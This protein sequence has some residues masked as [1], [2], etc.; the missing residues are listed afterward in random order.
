MLRNIIK[1]FDTKVSKEGLPIALKKSKEIMARR[2]NE[3]KSAHRN[4]DAPTFVDVMFINGCDYSVP[5]PI[6]YRVDHQMQQ[7]EAAGLSCMKIDAWNLDLDMARNARSFIIF[8]CPY[9]D[10][11]GDFIK[12]VKLLNKKVYFDIDDLVID[13][14]YTDA[15]PYVQQ[16]GAKERRDY[17]DGVRRMQQTLLAC[18]SAITSTVRLAEE[19]RNYVPEVFINRNV[20]SEE[21]LLLSERAIKERD[22]LPYLDIKTVAPEMRHY[23]KWATQTMQSKSES[24]RYIGY[25]SG[26][27][28][29][30]DDLS[31][32]AP[33][34]AQTLDSLCNV[35]IRIVG[36]IELPTSLKP[37]ENRIEI[38]PFSSW[39]DLPNLIAQVDVN[40]VP[41]TNTIF[42]EAK[43][44]NKW[45][46]ASLVK[47]PTI[48]S[49]IGPF[50]RIINSGINGITCETLSDWH[51]ALV[52]VLTDTNLARRLGEAAYNW[53][54]KYA[55]TINT[56]HE[57]ATFLT[58]HA[59]P[60]IAFS[61]PGMDI[62]GGVLVALT[63]AACLQRAG[64]D[65]TIFDGS[66][67]YKKHWYHSDMGSL[68]VL[69]PISQNN[70]DNIDLIR[71]H[72]DLGVATMWVTLDFLTRNALINKIAYL[73]Q[74]FEP[75]LYKPAD[76]SRILAA[77]TY[78]QD[79]VTYLTISPWCK[80]WLSTQWKHQVQYIP[81]GL[82]ISNFTPNERDWDTKIRILIEGDSL[83]DY[84]N[85]DE[86]FRITNRWNKNQFEIWYMSYNGLPKSWYH[87]DKFLHKVPH[88]QVPLVYQ[89]C[90]ILLKTSILES[91]SYP[92]LE[93][94]ATGG[95]VVLIRN[96]GNSEYVEDGYN[97]LVYDKGNIEAAIECIMR[98]TNNESLRK[99]LYNGALDT[100]Q[101]RDWESLYPTIKSVYQSILLITNNID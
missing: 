70:K 50:R 12:Q 86:A 17:D 14:K 8:R 28:T 100:A 91:F 11:I 93:M 90:H 66:L 87:V 75:D 34:L 1:L 60:N 18:G 19:L 22:F 98:L 29:H 35:R 51:E 58:S 72:F 96:D 63:H 10:L 4:P 61:L 57:L 31:M 45:V 54:R 30:S 21:M 94:M 85:V 48:A 81:N 101:K 88:N 44:E 67:K 71:G 27:I 47:V 64:F 97:C 69:S 89:D 46:E 38:L 32:V 3:K 33:A 65:I 42:N 49:N 5:H 26:S 73:V 13:T 55:V 23:V 59:T 80:E 68:P 56:G 74:G 37:Y 6:R 77:A 40:I 76:Y 53:C 99:S 39:K 2:L 83:S 15:I 41:L 62:S 24:V 52:A 84:K 82:H 92:P 78:N 79:N 43:S 16:L 20:A 25:F 7:L 9:N 36:L 95:A